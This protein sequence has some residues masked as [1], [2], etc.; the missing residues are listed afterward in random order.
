MLQGLIGDE[1]VDRSDRQVDIPTEQRTLQV[2]AWP[3]YEVQGDVF[4]QPPYDLREEV[5]RRTRISAESDLSPAGREIAQPVEDLLGVR[6]Q[7]PALWGEPRRMSGTVEELHVEG[8]LEVGHV[9]A[10]PGLAAEDG[11]SCRGKPAV[12]GH[13]NKAH[14]P[15]HPKPVRRTQL[16]GASIQA[17]YALQ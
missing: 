5:G 14:D 7:R 6:E 12:A 17:R 11:L 16:H 4:R 8:P 15:V 13:R 9:L 10:D 3:F 1:W 2:D